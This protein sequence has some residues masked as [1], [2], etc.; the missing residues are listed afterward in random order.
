MHPGLGVLIHSHQFRC[1]AELC[2]D[3]LP[4]GS[5]QGGGQLRPQ[6]PR[7]AE[8]T[9][10]TSYEHCD[11]NHP[12]ETNPRPPPPSL[13]SALQYQTLVYYQYNI[14]VLFVGLRSSYQQDS[15]QRLP[16]PT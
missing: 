12:K 2:E 9:I 16:T 1:V 14:A 4:A 7:A 11:T 8:Q 6:L 3:K 5:L 10:R 13:Q 15:K